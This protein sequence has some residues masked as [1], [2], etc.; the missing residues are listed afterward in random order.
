MSIQIS[1]QRPGF[2]LGLYLLPAIMA[3]LH[4]PG[5]LVASWLTGQIL[6]L[7]RARQR[8]CDLAQSGLVGLATALITLVVAAVSRLLGWVCLPCWLLL[9]WEQ[10]CR[11]RRR[12]RT[13]ETSPWSSF[14][15]GLA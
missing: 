11:R 15:V 1:W 14:G 12:R 4:P 9:A 10:A 2:C 13:I 8:G 7:W 5:W 3:V 6:G